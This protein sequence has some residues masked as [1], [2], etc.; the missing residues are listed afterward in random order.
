MRYKD[1]TKINKYIY[2]YMMIRKTRL[3]D[4]FYIMKLCI[5][6]MENDYIMN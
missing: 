4:K 1:E 6:Y 5:L 2:I 3:L